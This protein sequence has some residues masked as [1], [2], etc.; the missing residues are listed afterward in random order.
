MADNSKTTTE[1][2]KKESPTSIISLSRE[3]KLGVD[4]A[5]PLNLDQLYASVPEVSRVVDFRAG[6]ISPNGYEIFPSTNDAAAQEFA[7][8]CFQIIEQSG[9]VSFFEQYHKN[10]D[11]YGD[12]YVEL[13]ANKL[14]E[15]VELEHVH[16]YH[17]GYET[18][19][20]NDP[21]NPSDQITIIKVDSNSQKPVGF[22]SFKV[23]QATGDL[24]VDKKIPLEKIA[25][26]KFKVIGDSFNGISLIQPMVGSIT[27][28]VRLEDYADRS[29]RL[30]AV[31]KLILKG[32][33]ESDDEKKEDAREAANLDV[34]DVVVIQGENTS[35]DFVNPGK[36]NIPE[37]REMF[38]TN[39]TTA[40]GVPRP[41]LTSE[42]A[43]IN[44]ATMDELMKN[45][46]G[47]IKSHQ[48]HLSNLFEHIVF[49]RIAESHKIQNYTQII[50]K[51]YF[52]E[53]ND[54]AA[55]N[56]ETVQ[57]KAAALTSL[58][59]TYVLLLNSS[60]GT[61]EATGDVEGVAKDPQ[62]GTAVKVDTKV[63]ATTTTEQGK[64]PEILSEMEDL[65]LTTIKQFKFNND[66]ST[67]TIEPYKKVSKDTKREVENTA[68]IPQIKDSLELNFL[69]NYFT[70]FSTDVDISS[71]NKIS[72]KNLYKKALNAYKTGYT[73]IDKK[74]E[75]VLSI[76]DFKEFEKKLK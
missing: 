14:S 52:L 26:L 2:T 43:E 20:V 21:E 45:T 68:Y 6:M 5:N 67:H 29:A 60:T 62:N 39:I 63:N 3:E 27:R 58:T 51:L 48:L 4:L 37:L 61:T 41:A 57:R 31:P 32:N 23:D 75:K 24:I 22:A 55:A 47:I 69:N 30:I 53:D 59:N 42:S 11:L 34:N 10:T 65:L 46:R 36:T 72:Q 50:P 8:L 74:N 17:F 44:K 9:G 40:S 38:I 1:I 54:T 70:Q 71:E 56:V 35:V 64:L 18:E 13:V 28:K 33:Y 25:H 15:V 76:H 12:G 19:K 66:T 7:A 73:V 16:P 49:P